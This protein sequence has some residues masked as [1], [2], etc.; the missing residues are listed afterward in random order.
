MDMK[1]YIFMLVD[2]RGA[3]DK[4]LTTRVSQWCGAY[5]SYIMDL[6]RGIEGDV[7]ANDWGIN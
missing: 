3:F 2:F 4:A 7:I 6:K 5:I 1:I